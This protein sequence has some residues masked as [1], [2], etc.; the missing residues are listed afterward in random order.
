MK[1]QAQRLQAKAVI[2]MEKAADLIRWK[3]VRFWIQVLG[4][5]GGG[6]GGGGVWI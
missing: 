5:R 3:Q 6:G 4:R 2:A 1:A